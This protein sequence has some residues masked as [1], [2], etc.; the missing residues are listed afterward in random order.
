MHETPDLEGGRGVILVPIPILVSL[1]LPL[2]VVL[3]DVPSRGPDMPTR[4]PRALLPD[5]THYTVGAVDFLR[6]RI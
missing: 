6:L 5:Y 2:Y 1:L 3:I 4:A